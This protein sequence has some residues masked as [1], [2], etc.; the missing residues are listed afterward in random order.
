MFLQVHDHPKFNH[1]HPHPH[2]WSIIRSNIA[3]FKEE[4]LFQKNKEIIPEISFFEL[5]IVSINN[6]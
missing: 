4:T 5:F 2:L 6:Y 3:L 1:P